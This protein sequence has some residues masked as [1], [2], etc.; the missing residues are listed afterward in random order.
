MNAV[1]LKAKQ[2]FQSQITGE[3]KSCHIEEWGCEIYWKPMN[4]L[5]RDKIMKHV[6]ENQMTAAAVETVLLRALDEDGK[7][8]FKDADRVDLMRNVDP[9]IIDKIFGEMGGIDDDLLPEVE[10]AK[11]S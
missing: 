4:G 8:L 1:L 5:Q 9:K 6:F 2:H 3:M 11:E 10:E 7:R